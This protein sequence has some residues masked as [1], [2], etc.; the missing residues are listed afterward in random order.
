MYPKVLR[1][2]ILATTG[3]LAACG[4]GQKQEAPSGTEATT[5]SASTSARPAAFAQCM[6]CHTDV[7]GRMAGFSGSK[8]EPA[9][10][11]R[12]GQVPRTPFF[13][14]VQ[15]NILRDDSVVVAAVEALS[16][17]RGSLTDRVMAA[18]DAADA[19]GGDSRCTCASEPAVDAPCTGKTSHVAYILRATKNDPSGDSFNDGRYSLYLSVTDRDI[20]PTENANPVR[21]LRLRYE[22]WKRRA[23]R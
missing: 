8:N 16:R 6:M 3:L 15:G 2:L 20:R 10:L 11:D 21:T 5:T 18:M 23:R 4:G 13:F 12:Q 14:S 17:H 19:R 1:G 9:S 7:R 22:R